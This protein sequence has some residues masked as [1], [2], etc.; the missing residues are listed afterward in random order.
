MRLGRCMLKWKFRYEGFFF[1]F[2]VFPLENGGILNK[3][4]NHMICEVK[5]CDSR[6]IRGIAQGDSL[7]RIEATILV[8]AFVFHKQT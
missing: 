4:P 2:S 3:L 8:L 7:K 1:L 6:Y 5:Q